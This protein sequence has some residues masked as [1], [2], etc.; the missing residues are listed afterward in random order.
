MK[1]KNKDSKLKEEKIEI[2]KQKIENK[3]KLDK[4]R[5]ALHRNYVPEYNAYSCKLSV[6]W[7]IQ[8]LIL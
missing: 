3:K 1:K 2:E 8:K 6:L 4:G 5:R 7:Q